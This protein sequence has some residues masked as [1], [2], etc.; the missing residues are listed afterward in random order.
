[1]SAE[2]SVYALSR[3][4]FERFASGVRGRSA[5]DVGA[6][7]GRFVDSF[8]SH[9]ASRVIAVE[10]G[11]RLAAGLRRR[12]SAEARVVVRQEGLS[13]RGGELRGVKFHNCWTLARPGEFGNR[14]ADVSPGAE[15]FEGTGV[16]D[17]TLTT[18]DTLVDEERLTDLAFVKI[19]VDGYEARV[20]RGAER[21]L[22]EL[23]PAAMIE[24]SYLIS[25][26][27]D[28]VP[29]FLDHI[30]GLGYVLTSM[31]GAV[32]TRPQVLD[33]FPWHTSFDVMMLP[34]ELAASANLPVLP[35]R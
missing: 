32:A 18:L 10:P 13:E 19:D 24:L 35:D 33:A 2:P 15:A 9:G 31:K 7:E 14:L 16:F 25:D 27:G 29:E 6:N 12:F 8:L 28:S 30:Y 34:A 3:E 4:A 23:R 1:M 26:L 20:L 5:V 22:R 21:T 17:V 11:P